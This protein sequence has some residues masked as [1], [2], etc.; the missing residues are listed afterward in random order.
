VSEIYFPD[1]AES[2]G[3]TG[4]RFE[5]APVELAV[6][7]EPFQFP[8]GWSRTFTAQLDHALAVRLADAFKIRYDLLGA[9]QCACHPLPFPAARDYRRRTKHRNRRRR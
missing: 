5:W 1:L 9:A 6:E 8:A 3:V 4:L 2:F 7:P